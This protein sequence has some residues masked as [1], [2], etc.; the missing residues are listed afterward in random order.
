M[1][2]QPKGMTTTAKLGNSLLRTLIGLREEKGEILIEDVGSILE[3]MAGTLQSEAAPDIFLRKEIER[4]ASYIIAAKAEILSMVPDPE[5]E[6]PQNISKASMELGEVVKATE[7]ATNNIMDAAD[8][9]QEAAG[10]I[11]DAD[12]SAKIMDATI[13]IYDSCNF[14]DITGQ[15]INKVIRLLETVE[16]RIV[17][18]V[19]L[20]GGALPEGYEP[21]EHV[22][23]RDRPDEELMSGPQLAKD[24]PN[25]E[26]IDK[27]LASLS[28]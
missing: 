4:M 26:D 5:E 10:N 16:G 7:E 11:S 17:R 27:L 13:K 18:L 1:A 12:A 28:G 21:P 14:Q 19:E 8:V 3:Q 20:F 6:A 25:Q 2:E 15:R 24:A 9:I 22:Q 23:R